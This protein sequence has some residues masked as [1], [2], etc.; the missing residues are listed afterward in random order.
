MEGT[1]MGSMLLLD[2]STLVLVVA[3]LLLGAVILAVGYVARKISRSRENATADKNGPPPR[4]VPE[5]LRSHNPVPVEGG[6]GVGGCLPRRVKNTRRREVQQEFTH[7]WMAGR[8][9]KGHTAPVLDMDFS[10]NGKFLATCA[11]DRTVLLWCT[12]EFGSKE[13]RSLRINIEFDHAT[14]I[15]WSPDGKAFIIHKA[16]ANTIEVY[17]VAKKG[18]GFLASATKALEFP[19]RHVDDVVGMD[20]ACT[21]KYIITCST[22]N[23]LIIWDLKGQILGTVDMHLGTVHRARISPCGRFVAASG[24]TPDVKVWEV[25][26]SK[27][28]EFKQVSKAFDLAG[29][30]SGVFDFGFSAD[31]AQTATVSKDGTYRFYDTKIEF[32]KGEDPHLLVTG[33]WK[34]ATPAVLSLS[35]N[36]EVLVIGHGSSLSFYITLTGAFDATIENIFTGSI[37][38][39]VFDA[40]G[41]HVFVAGDKHIK[42]F[43]NVTGYRATIESTKRKLQ[44]K[45]TSATKERLESTIAE[46]KRFLENLG[47]PY[48]Q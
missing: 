45:Q 37:K 10:C 43:H 35:P 7:P 24:F 2:S 39:I 46:C 15:R 11:Q 28:G 17:K 47:E 27:S 36:G 38:K 40:M 14:L 23:D 20:I 33:S 41:E 30:S 3:T 16:M 29:H 13:R 31:T 26:F 4:L 42:I 12:K 19:K 32:E 44:H 48:N 6:M 21:G 1:E 25:V 5:H 22:A 9:L 34:V 18:D 8:D